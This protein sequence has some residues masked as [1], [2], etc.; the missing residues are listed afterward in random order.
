MLDK[1]KSGQIGYNGFQKVCK[2]FRVGLKNRDLSLLFDMFD[3][4]QSGIIDFLE[5]VD[6]LQGP[7]SKK[8]EDLCIKAFNHLDKRNSGFL[9]FDDILCKGF[10]EVLV[11]F[12]KVI[13]TQRHILMLKIKGEVRRRSLASF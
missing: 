13:I 10:Y 3:S 1:S 12:V 5:F 11:I 4:N 9:E 6:T 2:D 8:R 7:I